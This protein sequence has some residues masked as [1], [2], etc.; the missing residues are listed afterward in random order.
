MKEK[1]TYEEPSVIKVDVDFEE[2]IVAAGC[3]EVFDQSCPS[4]T[5]AS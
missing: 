4:V 5:S 2:A 1:K 3:G